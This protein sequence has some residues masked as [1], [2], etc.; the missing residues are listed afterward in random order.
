MGND[1]PLPEQGEKTP[2]I[3]TRLSIAMCPQDDGTRP[4]NPTW[5][6]GDIGYLSPAIQFSSFPLPAGQPS[7]VKIVIDNLGTAD[8]SPVTMETAY[9]IYIGNQAATMTNVQNMTIPLIPAG[10]THTA[11]VTWT[12]PDVF[13]AHA[14]FHARV[15]DSY[16]MKQYPSRCFSWDSYINPQAGSHNMILLKVGDPNQAIL[17]TYPVI[18]V[19][20]VAIEPKLLMTVIDD[21]GRFNNFA[22]RFPLP[23]VPEHLTSTGILRRMASKSIELYAADLRNMSSRSAAGVARGETGRVGR[24]SGIATSRR[25]PSEEVDERFIHHRFGIDVNAALDLPGGRREMRREV[26]H[27]R[28]PLAAVQLDSFTR[29]QLAP[30]ESKLVR[31]VIPPSEFPPPGRRKKFQLDYQIGDERPTQNFVYLYH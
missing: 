27:I 5:A 29:M 31:M 10:C 17:V 6:G 3:F 16:S 14:C 30:N 11:V 7:Q 18:N 26:F 23:F 15:F 9:N 4:V 1:T 12:P 24:I 21:L 19:A 28:Q 25:W 20:A 2:D 22:E 8:A 13:I